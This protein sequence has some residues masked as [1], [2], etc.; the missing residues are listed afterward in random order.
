M[1]DERRVPQGEPRLTAEVPLEAYPLPLQNER[2]QTKVAAI[3]LLSIM[4]ALM[5]VVLV[6]MVANGGSALNGFLAVNFCIFGALIAWGWIPRSRQR[7]NFRFLNA[8]VM[9]HAEQPTADSWVHLAATRPARLA[10]RIAFAWVALAAGVGG[11]AAA[12][13]IA[14][15]M[16]RLN[17][18]AHTAQLVIAMVVCLALAVAS[19]WTAWIMFAQAVRHRTYGRRPS[20]IT[21]GRAGV[22]V[23]VPGRDAEIPWAIIQSID[24]L[25]MAVG[26]GATIPVIQMRLA[27]HSGIPGDLQYVAVEGLMVPPDAVYTA[28]QW[29]FSHPMARW[30]LSRSE[31]Q[32]RLDG[33]CQAAMDQA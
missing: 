23:R 4:V 9:T 11:A 27:E 30:E 15:V 22:S 12:A 31:G 16:P 17:E 2:R 1:N 10:A 5:V 7:S 8:T 33:W 13:Q 28:L 24:A 6:A 19:G 29:Y 3:I 26:R 18:T 20:G 21:L 14:G 25:P 32:R